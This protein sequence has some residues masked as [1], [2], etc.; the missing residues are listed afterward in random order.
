MPIKKSH[1][2]IILS[3][4]SNRESAIALLKRHRPYLEMIPSL[5]RPEDSIV[6]LPLP[7]ARI[8]YGKQ[9]NS[10]HNNMNAI[11]DINIIEATQIPCD[12]A[13]LMCDPEW[14]IKMGAEI[15]VFIHRP[16]EDF[17]D[18]LTRWRHTQIT[19]DKDY[20]WMMPIQEQHMLSEGGDRIY[21]L[22]LVM[23]ETP[24]RIKK[25][26]EGAEL[27]FILLDLNLF[28]TEDSCEESPA[29]S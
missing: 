11:N 4:Y 9:F 26:L 19:L 1:Y 20:E 21:P 5:R 25:G 24:T 23:E 28:S 13:I 16:D 29:L 14:K 2:E 6:I 22:F 18:L 10:N 7:V 27:P 3:E 8:R 12:L 15:M 17:S